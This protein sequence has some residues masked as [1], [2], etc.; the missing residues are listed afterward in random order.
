MTKKYIYLA[1][2]WLLNNTMKAITRILRACHVSIIN[3]KRISGGRSFIVFDSAGRR[4]RSSS[5][6][7][8]SPLSLY[9]STAGD[10]FASFN[11]FIYAVTRYLVDGIS[12]VI[13]EYHPLNS[14]ASLFPSSVVSHQPVLVNRRNHGGTSSIDRG[15]YY[16]HE[17]GPAQGTRL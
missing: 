13:S 12:S 15:H 5:S 7:S 14:L 16:G 3:Q 2:W 9:Y 1:C 8:T 11:Y 17:T 4:S 10:L 6:S